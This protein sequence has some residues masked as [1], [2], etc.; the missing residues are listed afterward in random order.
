MSKKK[1]W[2]KFSDKKPAAAKCGDS[3]RKE[4]QKML[5]ATARHYG[6]KPGDSR[7][8]R[9]EARMRAMQGET[10]EAMAALDAMI[11]NPPD[12]SDLHLVLC[13]RGTLKAK[14]GDLPGAIA[15]LDRA[16]E[17][18][19]TQGPIWE[20][21]A[22]IKSAAGDREG[23]LADFDE[24]L[25]R[26]PDNQRTHTGR[27]QLLESSGALSLSDQKL[28]ETTQVLYQNF[29]GSAVPG[30]LGSMLSDVNRPPQSDDE[31]ETIAELVAATE[32]EP[33]NG[34]L[35]E[36]LGRE[37]SGVNDWPAA[38]KAFDRA[39]KLGR[40]NFVTL[41]GRGTMRAYRGESRSGQKDLNK[42]IECEPHNPVGYINRSKTH[43]DLGDLPAALADANKAIAI[44]EAPEAYEARIT[45]RIK[46]GDIK[47]AQA[48]LDRTIELDAKRPMMLLMRAM[49]RSDSGD[50]AGAWEDCRRAEE[51]DPDD[52][53]VAQTKEMLQEKTQQLQ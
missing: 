38:E 23:A 20:C 29:A 46:M 19:D 43:Y 31:Q 48:D 41:L 15:D 27:K 3:K 17:I 51:I 25:R 24:A 36:K 18:D 35:F 6:L 32:R 45:I 9:A 47:G 10:G 13:E 16:L 50:L 11:A 12:A 1:T 33:D 30:S 14:I 7:L 53:A 37:Y 4:R 42:A 52:P 49:L 40:H 2:R 34:E 5:N 8:R 22:R 28:P 39:I 26:E 21:R 44:K